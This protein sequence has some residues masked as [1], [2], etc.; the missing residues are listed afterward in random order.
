MSTE[1]REQRLD[2]QALFGMTSNEASEYDRLAEKQ[3]RADIA[4]RDAHQ[5]IIDQAYAD[6]YYRSLNEDDN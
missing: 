4:H 1:T 2:R 3:W 6:R 5:A